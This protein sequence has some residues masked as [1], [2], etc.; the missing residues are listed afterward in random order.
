M[1]HHNTQTLLQFC[2]TSDPPSPPLPSP[3][4]TCTTRFG[5]VE[6]SSEEAFQNALELNGSEVEGR[7]I[8][9]DKANPRGGGGGDRGGF[10]G[11]FQ[12]RGRGFGNR[13]GRGGTPWRSPSNDAE[14]EPNKTLIVMSLPYSTSE[15]TL[16]KLFKGAE[17]VRIAT[18]RE[19]GRSRG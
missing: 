13:G 18:D 12:G 2:D 15:M 8:R 1:Q 7:Q 10:R 9:V 19:T 17:S 5:Y 16:N 6:F 11:N 3:P 14:R 4:R